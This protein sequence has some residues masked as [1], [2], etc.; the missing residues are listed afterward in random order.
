MEGAAVAVPRADWA[1]TAREE[2]ADLERLWQ[3]LEI[4]GH[5]VE[6]IDGQLVVSPSA[7]RWHSTAIDRLI[8]ALI[9]VKRERGW[10]IHTNLTVHI[11]ATRERLIPDLM[12]A[13]PDAPGF[14][15]DELLAPGIL[16]AAEV[17]SPSSQRQD[18]AAKPRAYAQG[19]VPLFLLIDAVADPSAVT[20][21]SRPDGGRYRRRQACGSDGS[22]R[23]PEPFDITIDG[24]RLLT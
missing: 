13:P 3:D 4:P 18:R 23:V 16:L 2:L 7:S 8:D 24:K 20:L 9:D 22:L 19:E 21:F 1:A 10:V 5:R 14:G 6:L 12:I 17:V 11:P 15:D